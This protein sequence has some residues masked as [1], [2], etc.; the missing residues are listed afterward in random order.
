MPDFCGFTANDEI[1]TAVKER[2]AGLDQTAIHSRRDP[3]EKGCRSQR[4][5]GARN[6]NRD[7]VMLKT[8]YAVGAAA[9][10]VGAFLGFLSLSMQ[11]EA[12]ARASAAKGDRADIRTLARDCSQHAWPYFEAGCLRDTRN[13]FG[14][15]REARL[16]AP[17]R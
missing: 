2:R 8:V 10:V 14:Q 15:A 1:V 9:I 13:P 7:R 5:Q 6:Q 12:H 16:V 11:V 17:A 3:N 4:R